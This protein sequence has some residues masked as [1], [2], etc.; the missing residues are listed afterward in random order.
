VSLLAVHV[1]SLPVQAYGPWGVEAG[2]AQD[3]AASAQRDLD[4]VLRPWREKFPR[5]RV[6]GEVLDEGEVPVPDAVA[7]ACTLLGRDPMYVADEGC[8]VAFVPRR[9]AEAVLD[10][11]HA[12]PGGREAAVIGEC[13]AEHPGMV[14]ARTGLGGTRIVDLPLGEQLPRIC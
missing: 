1:R 14:G 6:I 2:A 9:H 3:I 13:V 8:L 5:V 4:E 12:H 11:M 7:T 10:A